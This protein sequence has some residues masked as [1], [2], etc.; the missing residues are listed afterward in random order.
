MR[1]LSTAIFFILSFSISAQTHYTIDGIGFWGDVSLWT[2]SYPSQTFATDTITIT[3]SSNISLT[4]N[5]LFNG[6]I[7]NNGLL[8]SADG[9]YLQ[10]NDTLINNGTYI[11]TDMPSPT[12]PQ[13]VTTN[14]I[15][16]GVLE[17]NYLGGISPPPGMH[18]QYME[19]NGLVSGTGYKYIS[20]D[21][22]IKNYGKI[23]TELLQM[24]TGTFE[25]NDTILGIFGFGEDLI[26][27]PSK[28]FINKGIADLDR[29]FMLHMD[30]IENHGIFNA[31]E[32]VFIECDTFINSDQLD[33]G[34]INNYSVGFFSNT[35]ETLFTKS[36][37]ATGPRALTFNTLLN[38]NIFLEDTLA[39]LQIN[40]EIHNE[41]FF[42]SES[43]IFSAPGNSFDFSN[44]PSGHINLSGEVSANLFNIGLL[45][46]QGSNSVVQ[47]DR[48]TDVGTI[49][50][51]IS[52]I[53]GPGMPG[54]H[55]QIQVDS[56]LSLS[57][58]KLSVSLDG[59]IPAGTDSFNIIEST[60]IIGKFSTVEL[61]D[62]PNCKDWDLQYFSDRVTLYV[63]DSPDSDNDGIVDCMDNCPLDNLKTEPG[64]CGCGIADIDSDGDG[65]SDCH[66]SDVMLV[67]QSNSTV[68][69]VRLAGQD[70][71]STQL[72]YLGNVTDTDTSVMLMNRR[73]DALHFGT[74]NTLQMTL[75]EEGRLGIGKSPSQ[76]RLEVNGGASKSTPGDWLANSDA[77]LKRNIKPLDPATT[78]HQLLALHGVTY[79]WDDRGDYNRPEGIQFGLTA[80]NVQ[81]VFPSLVQEGKDGWLVTSYGTFDPM[82]LAA[83][84]ALNNEVAMMRSTMSLLK[85][86][87]DKY[88]VA[89]HS[90]TVP[91]TDEN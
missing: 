62:L 47:I 82:F 78:L 45:T 30:R 61:P 35:G 73:D 64:L 34:L 15:N 91:K 85:S 58:S 55:Q 80:Q 42:K 48:H 72:W 8:T 86:R 43:D 24:E 65:V 25:N 70:P 29:A 81:G 74:D 9:L 19:N 1:T 69:G 10:I 51:K 41:G 54:G 16:N 83:I 52:G 33:V 6:T 11:I 23:D 37:D 3:A 5:V 17:I 76:Y 4:S 68:E 21:V 84:R 50:L 36:E 71:N 89:K 77:R 14:L 75:D 7:I 49:V 39:Y 87:L 22:A 57:E 32:G 44:S 66:E 59:Y 60:N 40:D 79:E 13:F 12:E 31:P 90:S 67:R 56:R 28:V 63:I 26:G 27:N 46:L 18:I 53:A 2:P 20:T 88:E 38:Y